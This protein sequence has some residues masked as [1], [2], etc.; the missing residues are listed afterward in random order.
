MI[1]HL[2]KTEDLITDLI[3]LR[4]GLGFIPGRVYEASSFI[5]V[6][7]GEDQIFESIKTRF[8]SA[9]CSLPDKVQS[10]ALLAAYGL[11]SGYESIPSLNERRSKYG[12]HIGRKYDTLADRESAAIEELAVRLLTAYYSGAPLPAELPV[13]HGGFLQEYLFVATLIKDRCFIMH[14]QARK[15]I[16]LVTGAKGF[17]YHSSERTKIT[18]IEGLEEVRTRNVNNGTIHTLIFPKTLKRGQTHQFSF[19][20]VLEEPESVNNITEDFAGQSFETPTLNYRQKVI[21]K[22]EKPEIIWH[23]DKLSRI[24]RP[25]EPTDKNNLTIKDGNIQK[26]F[27]QLYGGLHSGI[28]WRWIDFEK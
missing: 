1:E 4:K 19:Q 12:K 16:S 2:N 23:Y 28:A 24:E 22:G 20:E 17:E 15:I 21:F 3:Y 10:E 7:G 13:P 25:S 14:Q 11:L 27:T 26:E 8:I 6:I 5:A 9:I 18:P